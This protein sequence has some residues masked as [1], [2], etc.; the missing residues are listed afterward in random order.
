MQRVR[1]G[2]LSALLMLAAASAAFVPSVWAQE[3]AR[4]RSKAP[5]DARLSFIGIADGAK[6][7]GKFL[8]RFALSGM[9]VVPAGQNQP[10]A[11]HHHILIDT[12][13]PPLDQPI[14]SDFNHLHLGSG[15]TEIEIT[16][17]PGRHTLQLLFADHDHVPHDPPVMSPRIT[18][19]VTEEADEKPRVASPPGARVFFVD[20]VDGA[21]IPSR[22]IIRFGAEG[23]ALSPA[24]TRHPNGGH[25]H[26]LIDTELPPLDREIPSDFNHVHF[27]RGQ[28]EA[29]ITLPPGEHTLQLLMGDHDHVPHDPPLMSPR[30]RV[31]VVEGEQVASATPTTR[32]DGKPV[33][34]PAPPDAAVYFI[35]PRDGDVIFPNTTVRF[36]LRNMGVAPAGVAKPNTG[37]H[38]LIVNA[39]TPPLDEAIPADLNHIHLGGGQTERRITL[40]RGEHTLQLIFTDENH[41]PH[42]PPIIS[43]RIRVTVAPGGRRPERRR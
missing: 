17:P 7:P 24:G 37:H 14:P 2:I 41:V 6:L 10:N 20:L 16:L 4:P 36:G 21:T 29:E 9:E 28:T 35:Y 18:V 13:L 15:Q 39:P 33:L 43:E 1:L 27:G 30:I 22:S 25:H 3:A 12:D 42:D 23:V 5:A 34:T 8:V 19:E 32:P 11:G 26:L 31:R 40:P 38:H